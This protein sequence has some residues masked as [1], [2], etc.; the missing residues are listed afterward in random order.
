MSFNR[1]TFSFFTNICNFPI[2]RGF[3]FLFLFVFVVFFLSFY[4]LVFI[5]R[6]YWNVCF[7]L[8]AFQRASTICRFSLFPGRLS[9]TI[10]S[11]QSLLS[12]IKLNQHN[13]PILHYKC[14]LR[15]IYSNGEI[16]P[17]RMC[18]SDLQQGAQNS[19]CSRRRMIR[20]SWMRMDR[21]EITVVGRE[22]KNKQKHLLPTVLN[23]QSRAAPFHWLRD[24][25]F[26]GLLLL[27]VNLCAAVTL[28]L[29]VST[30]EI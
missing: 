20:G 15:W 16:L 22:T 13:P 1:F 4:F 18:P 12:L 5:E 10:N 29:Y 27:S 14:T 7:S 30:R 24:S 28:G 2:F 26:N 11:T 17:F 6:E 19:Y 8:N 23:W 9:P 21:L 3:L 25:T